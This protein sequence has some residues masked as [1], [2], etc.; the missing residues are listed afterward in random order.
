MNTDHI[1]S[2]HLTFSSLFPWMH[3]C[4]AGKH[5][6]ALKWYVMSEINLWPRHPNIFSSVKYFVHC[7][8]WTLICIIYRARQRVSAHEMKENR[9]YIHKIT[10]IPSNLHHLFTKLL[11]YWFTAF[12][13]DVASLSQTSTI[14]PLYIAELWPKNRLL[15]ISCIS[16]TIYVFFS[17]NACSNLR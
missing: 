11:I 4:E 10:A 7:K 9:K 13:Q 16:E 2:R 6:H 14:K 12:S 1:H 17:K 15:L 8:N 5:A 3:V